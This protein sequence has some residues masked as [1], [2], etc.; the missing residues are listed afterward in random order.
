MS[1]HKSDVFVIPGYV[2]CAKANA[3]EQIKESILIPYLYW[4]SLDQLVSMSYDFITGQRP[5]EMEKE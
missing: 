2:N 1:T 3:V 5:Q 4:I